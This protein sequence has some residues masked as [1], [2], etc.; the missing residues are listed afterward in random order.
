MLCLPE[1]LYSYLYKEFK[2]VHFHRQI[3]MTPLKKNE[4]AIKIGKSLCLELKQI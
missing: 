2:H 4:I 3:V 1:R